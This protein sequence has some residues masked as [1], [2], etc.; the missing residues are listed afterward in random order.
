MRRSVTRLTMAMAMGLLVLSSLGAGCDSEPEGSCITSIFS[1]DFE[2]YGSH[3]VCED[4]VTASACAAASGR[5][6]EDGGC[7]LF[8]LIHIGD[9]N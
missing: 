5:F 9:A 1:T 8:T 4:H 3:E 7:G 2:T 6:D